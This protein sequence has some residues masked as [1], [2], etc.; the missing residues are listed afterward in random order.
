[1]GSMAVIAS[2]PLKTAALDRTIPA[3]IAK[4]LFKKLL[5]VIMLNVLD[6]IYL[7]TLGFLSGLHGSG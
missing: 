1:M 2:A 5:L 4:D 6:I 7:L 3:A